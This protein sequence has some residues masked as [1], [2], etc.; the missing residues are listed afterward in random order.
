[1]KLVFPKAIRGL[2][3]ERLVA[4]D[5]NNFDVREL[6]P[7]LFFVIVA[8]G[9]RPRGRPN[10][11]KD[12]DGFLDK[13]VQHERLEGFDDAA[14][15]AMLDRWVRASIIEL[16]RVGKARRIEQI[17]YVEPLSLLTY[18]T[19]LPRESGR[20]RRVDLYLYRAMRRA[21]DRDGVDRAPT[22]LG[23]IFR[24]A[25]G[26]E[27]T[28]GPAPEYDGKY[29]G[30]PDVDLHT[31]LTLCYLDGFAPTPADKTESALVADCPATT[32]A[33][34]DVER[35]VGEDLLVFILAY[36]D[37]T[38]T[39]ALTDA[40]ATLIDLH[41]FTGTLKLAYATDELV[42]SGEVPAAM[43]RSGE[44][45]PPEI[46]VD[47]T[48]ERG[49]PSDELAQACVDRDL[50]MLGRYYRAFMYLRT[51]D[52]AVQT[53][54]RLR[55][56]FEELENPAYLLRLVSSSSQLQ[57]RAE[58]LLD[59]VVE[60]TIE[61]SDD[62]DAAEQVRSYVR[63][64]IRN[65]EGDCVDAFGQLLAESQEKS[66]SVSLQ[67]WYWSVG[68]LRSD[69]GLIE[70]NL[71]GRRRARYVMSDQLLAV[72]VQLALIDRGSGLNPRGI[73]SELALERF[74]GWLHERFGFTIDRP[75]AFMDGAGARAAARDNLEAM[76]R[77]LRQ[78]GYFQA[79]S[80]DFAAQYLRDP[81]RSLEH[82]P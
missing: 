76:K 51:L 62:A 18:K 38:S 2:T 34:P 49:S 12:I 63:D 1:V 46:Y 61:E 32:P 72:L 45:T 22:A 77:R 59:A 65:C 70:G 55:E 80:D 11:P 28:I 41:L 58:F 79:L 71:M 37:R 3:F 69:H 42:R 19:G 64:V 44:P 43:Q 36:Q 57:D 4:H 6:L 47:F 56:E 60:A 24:E 5:L 78:M 81:Q 13:L 23:R 20:R 50:E 7:S 14:G 30:D 25:F 35:N 75:P 73:R 21:L 9:R 54:T 15:R 26:R 66:L 74:L 33:L 8:N 10:E 27:V 31:L 17:R 68:G 39:I 40:L 29:N 82:S 16:S 53:S 52:H 67:K 48:R